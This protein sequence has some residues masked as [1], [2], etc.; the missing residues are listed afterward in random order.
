MKKSVA[1]NKKLVAGEED[2]IKKTDEKQT[3]SG[4]HSSQR[5]LVFL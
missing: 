2:Q 3:R 1:R 5:L 4:L